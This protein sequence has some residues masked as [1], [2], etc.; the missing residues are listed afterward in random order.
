MCC[1]MNAKF[2][3]L[4]IVYSKI[5]FID[6]EET[7]YSESEVTVSHYGIE[8]ICTKHPIEIIYSNKYLSGI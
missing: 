7:N 8:T 4:K 2:F 5:Y 6:E 1:A 3:K